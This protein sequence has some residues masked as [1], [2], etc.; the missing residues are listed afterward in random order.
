MN[1]ET[2]I[3]EN[4]QSIII[5]TSVKMIDL[6]NSYPSKPFYRS[7]LEINENDL[8]FKRQ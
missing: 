2:I 3:L 8:I 5:S 7:L 1:E 6:W 4:F